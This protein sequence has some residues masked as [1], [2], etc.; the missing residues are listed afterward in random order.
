MISE[1]SLI[2]LHALCIFA[3]EGPI[4]YTQYGAL[5]GSL[6]QTESGNSFK[7]ETQNGVFLTYYSFHCGCISLQSILIYCYISFI[8]NF[9]FEVEF[10]LSEDFIQLCIWP[11]TLNLQTALNPHQIYE[12][13]LYIV[14][15]LK[16]SY[17]P[18]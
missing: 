4:V 11:T 2:L 16:S 7:Q 12:L 8:A 10:L 6:L 14:Y 3:Q 5:Q 15:K 13:M 9:I 18:I 17:A 1:L